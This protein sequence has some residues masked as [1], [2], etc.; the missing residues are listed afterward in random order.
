MNRKSVAIFVTLFSAFVLSSCSGNST[1]AGLGMG[2]GDTQI[3]V[4]PMDLGAPTDKGIGTLENSSTIATPSII[5]IGDMSISTGDVQ[6][7]FNEVKTVVSDLNG[8]VEN[9]SYYQP[10]N[11]Y[12]PSAF[13][14]ARIPE[15]KLDEAV[16]A[17]GKLGKQTSLNLNT[18]DV[19]LQT[20][21]L[22]AKV[23]ALT[24]SRDRLQQLLETASTTA[25]LLSA[26]QALAARQSELDSYNN[27]LDYLKTQVAE[28]TLNIQI[29]DDSTSLTIGLRGFKETLIEAVQNFLRAF[30]N[31]IIFIGTAIPWVLVFGTLYFL[32]KPLLGR[33][34]KGR[35]KRV[36]NNK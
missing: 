18:S 36:S 35:I 29:L 34:R 22:E 25:D 23:K 21:D 20:I 24:E 6:S 33:I 13:I 26:E 27:Q 2:G 32:L 19:T 12:G 3:G 17:I 11:G 1:D 10:T 5:R 9:S 8:R 28:S 16:S 31:I 4:T 14:T 15:G 30:E 7:V